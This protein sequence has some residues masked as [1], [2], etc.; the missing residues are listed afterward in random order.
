[1]LLNPEDLCTLTNLR[2]HEYVC[3][4]MLLVYL[5]MYVHAH[6]HISIDIDIDIY[7][8]ITTYKHVTFS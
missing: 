3:I 4:H 5:C 8:I 6:T 2:V 7:Q 1:M